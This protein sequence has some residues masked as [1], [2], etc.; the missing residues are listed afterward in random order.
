MNLKHFYI[1]SGKYK[2]FFLAFCFTILFF[3]PII[4]L[5]SCTPAQRVTEEVELLPSERLLKKLELNRRRIKT[6]EGVGTLKVKTSDFNN[7][8]YFKIILQKPDSINLTI[9]GPFGIELAK[10]LVTRNDFAFYDA[11]NNTVYKGVLSDEVLKEIFKVHLSIDDLLD[12][13][14]G[15]VNLTEKL[16]Q[17]PDKYDVVEDQYVLVYN[18]SLKGSMTT[19]SVDIRDLGI[20]SYNIKD[21]YGDVILQ[22]DYLKFRIFE[23]VAIPYKIKVQNLLE[24]QTIEIDYNK[25]SANEKNTKIDFRIPN[26]ALIVEW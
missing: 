23:T 19:Y 15:S 21:F 11:M 8:A 12:A 25:M 14:I 4:Y 24:N 26:D 7:S 1:N 6:F 9:M 22:G 5:N 13:F 16:Y 2:S 18:D 10:A 3:L 20:T 17:I